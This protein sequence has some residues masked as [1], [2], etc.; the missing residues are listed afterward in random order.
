MS[1]PRGD[2]FPE[3]LV[4]GG[5]VAGVAAAFAAEQR[6]A[7]VTLVHDRAGAT[8]LGSGALDWLGWERDAEAPAAVLPEALLRF[9]DALGAW[10]LTDAPARVV[11]ALGLTRPA[12]GVQRGVL[13]VSLLAGRR[14]A[15]PLLPRGDWDGAALCRALARDAAL[16]RL[17]VRFDPVEV[18]VLRFR[19]EEVAPSRDLAA[20][21]DAEERARWLAERLRPRAAEAWLFGPWLGLDTPAS[22]VLSEALGVPVGE[23]LSDVGQAAGARL[24]A[25]LARLARRHAHVVEARVTALERDGARWLA[26]CEAPD[27]SPEVLSAA[28]VVLAS[29][30]L[31]A[32]GL[33]LTPARAGVSGG[34][35]LELS[36]A[37]GLGLEL[38]GAP[39]GA[40]SSLHGFELEQRGR[41]ALERLGLAPSPA[42]GLVAAGDALAGE[43]RTVLRSAHTGLL[44]GALG[45]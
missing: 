44:A 28:R 14:V 10:Q 33:T 18:S 20:A 8:E 31:G 5:G 23:T 36:F 32:G 13:D 30:G 37:P 25:A 15:V 43:A 41:F 17:G 6:G 9:S 12:R 16:S 35:R 26:R 4:I 40:A 21:H 24:G 7:R 11:T 42:P 38:D 22:E 45:A 39:L 29:G 3:L 27:G 19:A 34:A 1:G 2:G